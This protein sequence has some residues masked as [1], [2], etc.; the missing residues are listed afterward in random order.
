MNWI[1][2]DPVFNTLYNI[3]PTE[4]WKIHKDTSVVSVFIHY[5]GSTDGSISYFTRLHLLKRPSPLASKAGTG[6]ATTVPAGQDPSGTWCQTIHFSLFAVPGLSFKKVSSGSLDELHPE[7]VYM[8][9]CPSLLWWF[10][11]VFPMGFPY[12]LFNGRPG[13]ADHWLW[14]SVGNRKRSWRCCRGRCCGFSTLCMVCFVLGVVFSCKNAVATSKC[15]F[16]RRTVTLQTSP[17][18]FFLGFMARVYCTSFDHI[19]YPYCWRIL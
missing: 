15:H 7:R 17:N 6:L 10:T 16:L 12:G 11:F 18:M 9:K 14:W 2:K 8:K 3:T 19:W 1:A 4:Q 5:V 13:N